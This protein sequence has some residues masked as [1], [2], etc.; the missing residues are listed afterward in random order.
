MIKT[1]AQETINALNAIFEHIIQ[2]G[3]PIFS[4]ILLDC[5]GII[6]LDICDELLAEPFRMLKMLKML[7]KIHGTVSGK[8]TIRF[9]AI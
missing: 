4:L 9:F 1:S 7:L 2:A 5:E 8:K 3:R 6:Y